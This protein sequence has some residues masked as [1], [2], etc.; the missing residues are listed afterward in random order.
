MKLQKRFLR[1]AETE[2]WEDV[3][4]KRLQDDLDEFL[5]EET[6]EAPLH[7]SRRR[8]S[9]YVNN[10]VF[11]RFVVPSILIF[12]GLSG[13][14]Y[15]FSSSFK[16]ID[17]PNMFV[18]NHATTSD[19]AHLRPIDLEK[20]VDLEKHSGYNSLVFSVADIVRCSEEK[21]SS[22]EN[23]LKPLFALP[24]TFSSMEENMNET[25]M[26][27]GQAS[28]ETHR[29]K[30]GDVEQNML[31]S[32]VSVVYSDNSVLRFDPFVRSLEVLLASHDISTSLD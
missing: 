7:A 12:L 32:V 19:E 16:P 22:V 26:P 25:L 27:E 30:N 15:W 6:F 23:S 9:A 21:I 8:S 17:A 31:T 20:S 3:L 24:I 1:V 28:V 2:D 13:G 18:K 4:V 29:E 11:V 10:N 5:R 14:G